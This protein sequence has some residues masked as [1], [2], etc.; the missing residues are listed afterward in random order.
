MA[1]CLG[2]CLADD[3][4]APSIPESA[5]HAVSALDLQ[6]DDAPD[7]TRV[8]DDV[9]LSADAPAAS[10]WRTRRELDGDAYR[11]SLARGG[12]DLGLSFDLAT[13][14]SGPHDVRTELE[15]PMVSPLPSVSV[16]LLSS[17]DVPASS[18]LSRVGAGHEGGSESRVGI[19]W[20][21]AE[22]QVKFLR[23]GLGM[24]LDSNE[25]IT[26]RLRKGLFGVYLQHRF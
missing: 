3:G 1:V 9:P 6:R 20:K 25:S 4:T 13:R 16:G 21:P 22:S 23:E 18:L 11:F 15:G 12:L 14:A 17:R 24:R 10:H 19:Q 2:P 5:S 7:A 26:M 8:R